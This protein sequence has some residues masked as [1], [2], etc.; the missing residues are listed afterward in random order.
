M[1]RRAVW[2]RELEVTGDVLDPRPETETLLALALE[3][4]PA[5]RILDLGT[6]TG[7][8]ALTLLAEW[9]GAQALA[10]D[11]SA[12]ALQVAAR[13]AARLGVA[14]RVRLVQS[15]WFEQISGRFDLVVS[16][17]PY[18]TAAE[19]AGLDPDVRDWEPHLAL[20][21]GGDGLGAYRALAAGVRGHLAPGGR[22]LIEIGASQGPA[23]SDLFRAAGF[24][25][26]ELHR[27]MNGHDRIVALH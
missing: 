18:V 19:M 12:A 7:I 24:E 25:R 9:P 21:P 6:G 10:S 26:I 3:R 13:N 4:G 11:L 17:P 15:D 14:E 2:G 23:V 8:L 16:N 20:T 27:D 1:G 22:A 5:G